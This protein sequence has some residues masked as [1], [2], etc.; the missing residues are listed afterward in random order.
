MKLKLIKLP[1][2]LL[3]EELE[4]IKSLMTE[5]RLYGNLVDKENIL[6]ES[7]RSKMIAVLRKS[8]KA[9]LDLLNKGYIDELSSAVMKTG[10]DR[11]KS[12]KNIFDKIKVGE[13]NANTEMFFK[14]L[15]IDNTDGI[16]EYFISQYRK[17]QLLL[18]KSLAD[19]Y[20]INMIVNH[21]KGFGFTKNNIQDMIDLIY[22]YNKNIRN[23]LRGVEDIPINVQS[24]FL[25]KSDDELLSILKS[26]G[27]IQPKG[28]FGFGPSVNFP[29]HSGWKF[30]IFGENL[31]DSAFL[32]DKLEPIAKKY[33]AH[34]KVGG[35][36]QMVE[37]TMQVGGNQYG[38]QGVTMYI[39]QSVIDAGK[40]KEMLVSIQNAIKG[41]GEHPFTKGG[42]IIGDKEITPQIHYRYELTGPIP[43]GG[44]NDKLY[45][46]LYNTNKGGTYKPDD[47]EE[48]FK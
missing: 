24:Y 44:L 40:H 41:Y 23:L 46:I 30:H 43:P 29:N 15:G 36:N 21:Y 34:S 6:T 45:D 18:T 38:K 10:D 12:I 32:I 28:W 42:T 5:E 8:S 26:K 11:Y 2:K 7:W 39:P 33:G 19:K 3:T 25:N 47:V 37:P 1:H 35:P 14:N 20:D 27:I 31:A 4:R 17:I 9:D 48:I 22:P 16:I 13:F